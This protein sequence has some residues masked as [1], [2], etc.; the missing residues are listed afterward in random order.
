[1]INFL[2]PFADQNIMVK[3][4]S[5]A[6]FNGLKNVAAA[7]IR[8][9]LILTFG[10][11]S[12]FGFI[13]G[14]Y[15]LL[16]YME[17]QQSLVTYDQKNLPD[18]FPVLITR[19]RK[20]GQP[21]V[22]LE[23]LNLSKNGS[24]QSEFY[25]IPGEGDIRVNQYDSGQYRVEKLSD[26]R[27]LITLNIWVGG[28]DRKERYIYEIKD[29]RIFPLSYQLMAY[30]G[31]FFSAIPLGLLATLVFLLVCKPLYHLMTAKI[32]IRRLNPTP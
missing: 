31:W 10:V 26:T 18:R 8:T 19:T 32:A 11:G 5:T 12:L 9:I 23:F 13:A 29:N 3:E 15:A 21:T 1:M 16:S 7:I 6:G 14:F 28:G 2:P 20:D 25:Q 22:Q 17:S 30:F 24:I 4:R 27:K